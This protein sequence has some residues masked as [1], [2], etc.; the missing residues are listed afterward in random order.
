MKQKVAD[1][2]S[3]NF[4]GVC[5]ILN[6]AIVIMNTVCA[7]CILR[8]REVCNFVRFCN[9]AR[10]LMFFEFFILAEMKHTAK[11]YEFKSTPPF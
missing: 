1:G 3:G 10:K 11:C 6:R 7:L 8:I 4:C 5:P 2:M 9:C